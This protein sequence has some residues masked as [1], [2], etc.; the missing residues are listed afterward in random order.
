VRKR[1]QTQTATKESSLMLL[2]EART[3]PSNRVRTR[4]CDEWRRHHV[5]PRKVSSSAAG[6]PSCHPCLGDGNFTIPI[7][8]YHWVIWSTKLK[9]ARLTFQKYTLP[10]VVII[11]ACIVGLYH[12]DSR[13]PSAVSD[14]WW[15]MDEKFSWRTR[16]TYLYNKGKGNFLCC[17]ILTFLAPQTPAAADRKE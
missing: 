16:A 1:N 3:G 7:L 4:R 5:P 12:G 2:P 17:F 13:R 11:Y 9:A 15:L 10:S 14:D 6:R 8:F